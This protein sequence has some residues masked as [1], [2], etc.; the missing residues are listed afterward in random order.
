MATRA[1]G[2][3]SWR[4]LLLV[5]AAVNIVVGL[6]VQV[7]LANAFIPPLAA[8]MLL[9]VIGIAVLRRP[10]RA[11]PLLVGVV[12]ILFLLSNLP[13]ITD[14]L[15]HPSTF[16]QFSVTL[17]GTVAAVVGALA[18]VGALLGRPPTAVPLA[19]VALV[20][21]VVGVAASVLATLFVSNQAP[22]AG[23]VTL[24]AE[25]TN[26]V[27]DEAR[28]RAGRVRVHVANEDLSRHTFTIDAI[29]V[30]LEVPGGKSRR[31]EFN[32]GP[33]VYQFECKVPGHEDME[34]TLT[35]E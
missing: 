31:V 29:D 26:F 28:A 12:S 17:V 1:E 35:V 13:F 22:E 15:A 2:A 24:E 8:F 5:V 10:G 14:D 23:D 32:S 19:A 9:Y 16:L 11:G 3:A 30:D 21:I 20:V 33:G 4:R 18:M 6:L 25:E 7:A 27:P 34:G